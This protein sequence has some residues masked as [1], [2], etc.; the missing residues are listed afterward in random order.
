[1]PA[2]S[3]T[4]IFLNAG[5]ID[6]GG[7]GRLWVDLS[8]RWAGLGLRSLRC[9]LSGLGDSPFRPGQAVDE[10]FPL[11][12]LEDIVEIAAAASPED[13]SNVVL[14]GLCSGGYHAIE[15]ALALGATGVCGINPVIPHKPSELRS[16]NA[17]LT[18]EADSRRQASAARKWWVRALPA[19]DQLG[20][21]LN[22]MPGPV[23]WLV[24]RVA[25]EQSPP[26]VLR[27]LV[28]ARVRTL[29]VSG[30]RENLVIW[31]GES[32][33]RRRLVRS[34]LLHLVVLPDIDHELLKRDARALV[35]KIV[36]DDVL[37]A[38]VVRT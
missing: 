38:Y 4:A 29:M 36:T 14:V 21:L 22:R 8:R 24:N 16:E 35:S 37:G 25:V 33:A 23:W 30:E 28:D 18:V 5:V 19:H 27:K 9:D 34:G 32:R 31:R 10:S 2:D 12:A 26:S 20:A 11:E 3:P 7:P 13:P 17:R 6:H 1:M 15:G